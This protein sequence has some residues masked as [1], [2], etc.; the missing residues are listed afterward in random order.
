MAYFNWNDSNFNFSCQ[1]G[2]GYPP[3][4]V[5]SGE[6]SGPPPPPGGNPASILIYIHPSIHVGLFIQ[7]KIT[8]RFS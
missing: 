4:V 8:N 3:P 7:M 2:G 5:L 1:Q 6:G